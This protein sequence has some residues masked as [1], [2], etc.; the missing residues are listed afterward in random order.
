MYFITLL[1]CYFCDME[2]NLDDSFYPAKP[3]L[4][5]KNEKNSWI[6]TFVSILL[7]IVTFFLIFKEE[8]NFILI[9]VIVLFIHELGHFLLMKLFNYQNVKMYF[10]PLMGAFV[11]GNKPKY[12]QFES[13]LVVGAGPF[14]GII[15]GIVCAFIFQSTHEPL[16]LTA[17]I[18]FFALNM[19]NL[20]PLDPLDGGQLFK[21]LLNR[22]SNFFLL[23]FSFLSSLI[24][25]GIGLYLD[26]WFMI[27][28]GF[29]LGFRVRNMQKLYY[30]RK[31]LTQKGINYQIDY[32]DLP[33]REYSLIKNT[34]LENSKAL[35]KYKDLD[36]SI[37]TEKLIAEQVKSILIAPLDRDISLLFK[38]GVLALW[39]AS[40]IIPIMVL[41]SIDS[42]YINYGIL[43]R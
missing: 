1:K 19:I 15:L 12:S 28:F 42:Y 27:G 3:I 30:I 41:L 14:P 24:L 34:L 10:V 6:K 5:E 31:E 37:D 18:I 29:I 38:I 11:Q 21:L 43:F 26:N 4:E 2:N 25:I 9:L 17:S 8:F 20:L 36:D 16:L 22:N 7:F 23:I 35:S 32:S 39:I 40:F 33:N 13:L